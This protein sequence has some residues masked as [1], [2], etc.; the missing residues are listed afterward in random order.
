MPRPLT[1]A[2]TPEHHI[3]SFALRCDPQRLGSLRPVLAALPGTSIGAEDVA[4]GKIVMVMEAPEARVITATLSAIQQMPGVA[5]AALVYQH[6]LTP[7]ATAPKEGS[8][9]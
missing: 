3:A 7:E 8:Q 5:H 1:A 9:P 4:S 6:I 2:Q